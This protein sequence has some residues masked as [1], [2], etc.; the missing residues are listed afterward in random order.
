MVSTSVNSLLIHTN[1]I[2]QKRELVKIKPPG[3][4]TLMLIYQQT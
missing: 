3:Q 2:L 4:V 1:P